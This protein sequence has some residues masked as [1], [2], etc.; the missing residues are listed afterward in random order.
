MESDFTTRHHLDS[1]TR[2]ADPG[3]GELLLRYRNPPVEPKPIQ[4]SGVEATAPGTTPNLYIS[5]MLGQLQGMVQSMANGRPND[6]LAGSGLQLNI[7]AD[8]LRWM[9]VLAFAIVLVLVLFQYMS[10]RRT[11]N[12]LKR[13]LRKLENEIR[14]LRAKRNPVDEDEDFSE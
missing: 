10:Y 11:R 6:N 4:F 5:N 2:F 12:P 3:I 7:N 1:V 14:A 9:I 13:R 8:I